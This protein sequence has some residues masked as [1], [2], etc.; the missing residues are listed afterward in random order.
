MHHNTITISKPHSILMNF[1]DFIKTGLPVKIPNNYCPLKCQLCHYFN[2]HFCK[3][4]VF[5][6]L[7]QNGFTEEENHQRPKLSKLSIVK[8]IIGVSYPQLKTLS[9]STIMAVTIMMHQYIVTP[10]LNRCFFQPKCIDVLLFL[11]KNLCYR[12]MY[13]YSLKAPQ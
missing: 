10:L 9:Q 2:K 4:E 12:Y 7:V 3:T 5:F 13:M 11:H 6:V 8:E 1:L